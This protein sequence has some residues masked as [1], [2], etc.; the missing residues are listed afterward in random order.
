MSSAENLIPLIPIGKLKGKPI[1][2]LLDKPGYSKHMVQSG[3][4]DKC[5][6]VKNFIIN[7]SVTNQSESSLTPEHNSL[8]K[9]FLNRYV[10]L[11]LLK[12]NNE[13]KIKAIK[14]KTTELIEKDE[15]KNKFENDYDTIFDFKGKVK[16]EDTYEYDVVLRGELEVINTFK[17]KENILEKQEKEKLIK[18]S[19]INNYSEKC[20][21]KEKELNILN[22]K[23]KIRGKNDE[24]KQMDYYSELEEY[25]KKIEKYNSYNFEEEVEKYE[26]NLQQNLKEVETSR[27]Q[28]LKWES[29]FDNFKNTNELLLCKKYG[30]IETKKEL[31]TKNMITVIKYNNTNEKNLVHEQ[32]E[33]L[34]KD[35]CIQHPKPSIISKNKV[36]EKTLT[37]PTMP[38]MP[39]IDE[40]YYSTWSENNSLRSFLW[41]KINEADL[42]WDTGKYEKIQNIKN[43]EI[44]RNNVLKDIEELQKNNIIENF[45]KNID[46]YLKSIN[47][48]CFDTYLKKEYNKYIQELYREMFSFK[49]KTIFMKE[50]KFVDNFVIV[51]YKIDKSISCCELKPVVGEDYADVLRS[52]RNQIL[53]TEKDREN[54]NKPNSN[55]S[56]AFGDTTTSIYYNLIIDNVNSTE[57]SKEIL[58][59]IYN[60]HNIIVIFSENI[61]EKQNIKKYKEPLNIKNEIQC[62]KEIM[63][64]KNIEKENEKL[65]LE[66]ELLKEENKKILSLQEENKILKA[67]IELLKTPKQKTIK[68]YFKK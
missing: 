32:L 39:N 4:L 51:K 33:K 8:Q 29:H 55:S 59:E 53:K 64:M 24:R 43:L 65:I 60:Q 25:E 16:F 45:D 67:E 44:L 35:Y 11:E 27:E 46:N 58:T 61:F 41:F 26:K 9:Q 57:T 68:D 2:E 42:N 14:D 56:K 6:D 20:K 12:N 37:K 30:F 63:R 36:P 52:L 66:I 28:N 10:Q 40:E 48:E 47:E 49:F 54:C 19:L 17:L 3:S 23:I 13:K 18:E 21:E 50:I 34:K 7:Y 22:D 62:D 5:P 1:I 38:T 31:F 15:F